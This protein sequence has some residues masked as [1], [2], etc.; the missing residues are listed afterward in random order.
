LLEAAGP[1]SEQGLLFIDEGNPLF[2]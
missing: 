1:G 2:I